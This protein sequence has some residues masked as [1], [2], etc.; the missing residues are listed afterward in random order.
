[1]FF[2][3]SHCFEFLLGSQRYFALAIRDSFVLSLEISS[4]PS[5]ASVL[6]RHILLNVHSFCSSV[7]WNIFLS[8]SIMAENFTRFAIVVFYDLEFIALHFY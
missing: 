5:S 2:S 8:P 6:F 4:V 7:L 3:Y 1:M